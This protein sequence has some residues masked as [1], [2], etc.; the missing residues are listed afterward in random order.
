MPFFEY[1]QNNSGG[2]MSQSGGLAS[3]VYIEATD[4]R[5]SRYKAKSLGIYFNGCDKGRDCGCCGDR[6]HKA[7]DS[8][9]MTMDGLLEHLKIVSKY[10]TSY[11]DYKI[12]MKD[13]RVICS[14]D[15]P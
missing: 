3:N 7:R 12:H 14:P 6:W 5:E 15:L 2:H 8:D 10:R 1:S 13:G 11:P 9:A 4:A